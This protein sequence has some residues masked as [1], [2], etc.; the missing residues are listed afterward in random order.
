MRGANMYEKVDI[1]FKLYGK[2]VP[3]DHG[4]Y[5]FSSIS[6]LLPH[7]H[8][9]TEVGIHPINGILAGNR[10][11]N[12]TP[13]SFL[14]I[15]LPIDLTGYAIELSGK[16][17]RMGDH[18]VRVGVPQTFALLPNSTLY[19]RLVVIKGFMEPEPFLEAVSRQ[20]TQ[21]NIRG[22]ASLIEN[23]HFE[24][25]SNSTSGTHSPFLRRTIRIMD[26]E[27]VG[28]A[29]LIDNLTDEESIILKEQGLG[30]RRRFGC[31]IFIPVRG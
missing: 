18:E 4:Y 31:G 15:R 29:L 1:K 23:D 28:F 11:L 20:L 26:K 30:G 19:S 7:I 25:N 13:D 16:S 5:L 3:A 6:K 2:Q 14:T 24:A 17:I 21:L 10:M 8:S 22:T 9:N 27:V 12:I